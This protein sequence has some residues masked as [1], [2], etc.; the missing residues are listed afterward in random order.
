MSYHRQ[1]EDAPT[2]MLATNELRTFCPISSG[3]LHAVEA[4][5]D[6]GEAV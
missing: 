3:V 5:D 1:G 4:T 2:I 6:R